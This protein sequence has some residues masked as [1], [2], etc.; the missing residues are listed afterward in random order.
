MTARLRFAGAALILVLLITFAALLAKPY[1][2]N[3]QFQRYLESLAFQPAT[4]QDPEEPLHAQIANQ[5]AL[6]GL[7]IRYEQIRIQRSKDATRIEARYLVPV[8]LAF[9][10]VDLHFHPSAGTR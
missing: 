9:Y 5:A 10:N 7:P 8:D 1:Y 6:L 4:P 3:W 2:R